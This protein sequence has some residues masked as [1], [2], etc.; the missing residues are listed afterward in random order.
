MKK[1]VFSIKGV[2]RKLNNWE[3]IFVNHE[4]KGIILNLKG[5]LSCNS[6]TKQSPSL[7]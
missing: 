3:E 5:Q 6:I 4:S 1:N 2:K 7:I